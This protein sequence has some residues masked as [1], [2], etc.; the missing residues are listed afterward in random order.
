MKNLCE[1]CKGEQQTAQPKKPQSAYLFFAA[2]TC[3]QLFE[4]GKGEV[5]YSECMSKAGTLWGELDDKGKEKY[6]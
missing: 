1:N 4:E 3:K 5:K 2:I 6:N